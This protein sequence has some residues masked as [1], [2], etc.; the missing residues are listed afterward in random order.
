MITSRPPPVTF[1]E[2]IAVFEDNFFYLEPVVVRLPNRSRGLQIEDPSLI[3]QSKDS[4]WYTNVCQDEIFEYRTVEIPFSLAAH[5]PIRNLTETEWRSIG[6]TQSVGWENFARNGLERNVLLFR[7]PRADT[8]PEI[9]ANRIRQEI[10]SGIASMG[11]LLD[12]PYLNDVVRSGNFFVQYPMNVFDGAGDICGDSRIANL[13]HSG[14]ELSFHA[15]RD[16]VAFQIE[17]LE[18]SLKIN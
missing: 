18:L 12:S 11:R 9:V 10:R 16:L 2:D 4:I 15:P 3:T 14:A 17:V 5:L 1:P 8:S 13:V 6:V 7:R